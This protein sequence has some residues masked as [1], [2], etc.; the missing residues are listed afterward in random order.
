MRDKLTSKQE[1]YAQ[2][3]ASG[4]T[5]SAVY[6]NNYGTS[7][8]AA[9]TV[10]EEASRVDKHPKVSARILELQTATEAALAAVPLYCIYF[11]GMT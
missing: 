4:L 10:W 6:P 11:I 1:G 9:K 2:D 8:M 5:Q 7:N 3:R